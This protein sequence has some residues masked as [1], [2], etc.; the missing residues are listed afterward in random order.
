M[1]IQMPTALE[2]LH[3]KSTSLCCDVI[4][5]HIFQ[6][7]RRQ[8]TPGSAPCTGSPVAAFLYPAF[9][10]PCSRD[11]VCVYAPCVCVC[12]C[13]CVHYA[14]CLLA[15]LP[16]E[17]IRR[18]PWVLPAS[19]QSGATD[20]R[21]A[22]PRGRLLKVSPLRTGFWSSISWLMNLQSEEDEE[23]GLEHMD[24]DLILRFANDLVDD[25]NGKFF[26]LRYIRSTRPWFGSGNTSEQLSS[27]AS[28]WMVRSCL[29]YWSSSRGEPSHLVPS[30]GAVGELWSSNYPMEL[31]FCLL[32]T[33]LTNLICIC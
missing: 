12:V 28:P 29:L 4:L 22:G 7:S 16:A 15:F 2:K 19:P 3:Y 23:E 10:R 14:S 33:I 31:F 1:R 6:G 30:V 27:P 20:V 25:L 32:T 5:L 24:V 8:L 9:A 26:L 21:M 13:L 11:P 18:A 17:A